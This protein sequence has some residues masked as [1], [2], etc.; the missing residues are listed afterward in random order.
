MGSMARGKGLEGRRARGAQVQD[1]LGREGT[2]YCALP[3]LSS[4]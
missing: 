1:W 2:A 3:V 4:D